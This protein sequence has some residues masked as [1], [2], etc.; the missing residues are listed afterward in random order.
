MK[1]KKEYSKE[2]I[3][4]LFTQLHF[5][6][7]LEDVSHLHCLKNKSLKNWVKT[8]GNKLHFI[9]FGLAV[10]GDLKWVLKKLKEM[11]K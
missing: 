4:D 11:E 3:K 9:S 2:D 10:E 1:S 6:E 7:G 8:K 5:C